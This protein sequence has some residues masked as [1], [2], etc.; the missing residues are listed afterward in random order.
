MCVL[1]VGGKPEN[2]HCIIYIC[3]FRRN[4]PLSKSF[5]NSVLENNFCLCTPIGNQEKL[6]AI[7]V[8]IR[9][10]LL[11]LECQGQINLV[12]YFTQKFNTVNHHLQPF[13]EAH[14]H[15]YTQMKSNI[16]HSKVIFY[17]SVFLTGQVLSGL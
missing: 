8:K 13:K 3:I 17:S 10:I 15:T 2:L 5:F 7:N 11:S 16:S 12:W 4:V 1:G 14:T 9:S 6:C